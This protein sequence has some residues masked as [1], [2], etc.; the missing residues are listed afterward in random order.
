MISIL[1]QGLVTWTGIIVGLLF[2]V[3]FFGC[4][5]NF[6][7][8]RESSFMNYFRERHILL[9]RITFAFF[10]VHAVLGILARFFGIYI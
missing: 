3:S 6:N 8:F 9:M 10:L 7:Y 4:V 2:I 5:C 1:G